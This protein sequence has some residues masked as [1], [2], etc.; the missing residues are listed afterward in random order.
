MREAQFI[1]RN[2]DRWQKMQE[3]PATHPDETANEFI[4]LVEDLGFSKT[5]YPGS[6]VSKY[7]NTEAT[8][9]YLSIYENKRQQKSRIV[10]L[11]VRDL[12]L[13][14]AKHHFTLLISF[15]LFVFFVAIGFFSAKNDDTFVRQI[16]GDNYVDMTE[17]N[18]KA[19]M[20]FG[21]YG[22][23]NELLSFLYIYINNMIVALRSFAG[24][25]LLGIP[26]VIIL[27]KNGIMVGAFEY[28]FYSNGL[29]SNSLL[30][31]MVHGTLELSTFVVAFA[32]GLVLAKSWLFPGTVKRMQAFK[33][34]A[35]EGLI[36]ALSN[37]PL[38]GLAAFFEGFVTRHADMPVWLKLL[39]I[40]FSLSIIIGYFVVYPLRVK[41]K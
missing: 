41:K 15:I 9:R 36:I 19:G 28:L 38:L 20:P 23:G 12:P 24:G 8:K 11:F 27:I 16:L 13:I 10:Q 21:V 2:K 32:S 33:T 5:F 7:L 37:V 39:I 4:Q 18:I 25:I 34:G 31:I 6:G 35:K 14:I 22:Y 26:T 17:R 3:N 29:M 40:L 30:T 1:K